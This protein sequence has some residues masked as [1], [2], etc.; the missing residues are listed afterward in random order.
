MEG[1]AV[2]GSR[3]NNGPIV[4]HIPEQNA[5]FKSSLQHQPEG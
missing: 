2:R 5:G 4:F 3:A 1:N